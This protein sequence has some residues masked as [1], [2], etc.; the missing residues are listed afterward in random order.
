MTPR[1]KQNALRAHRQQSKTPKTVVVVPRQQS[2]APKNMVVVYRRQ[3][4]G[5]KNVEVE[6]IETQW[7]PEELSEGRW[8]RRL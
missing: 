7:I 5:P 6:F 3:V 1:T 2:I 8:S 4:M